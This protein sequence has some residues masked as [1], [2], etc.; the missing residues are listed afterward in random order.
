MGT[1]QSA[2]HL[3][4]EHQRASSERLPALLALSPL[5]SSSLDLQATF[6]AI[7][8]AAINLLGISAGM[9]AVDAALVDKQHPGGGGSLPALQAAGERARVYRVVAS[10]GLEHGPQIGEVFASGQ[11]LPGRVVRDGIPLLV[12][13]LAGDPRFQS[14]YIGGYIPASAIYAPLRDSSNVY[15]MLA[16]ASR[17]AQY[18]SEAD[19]LLLS[20]FAEQASHALLK[21]HLH[22]QTDE[23]AQLKERARLARD[24]H[25]MLE[26]PIDGM[27]QQIRDLSEHYQRLI[28]QDVGEAQ[29]P[30]ANL[31]D[32]LAEIGEALS[33]VLEETRQVSRN[34]HTLFPAPKSLTQLVDE[35]LS[36]I[37]RCSQIS[38][39]LIVEGTQPSLP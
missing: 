20:V 4:H 5:L 13:N 19:L 2:N 28:G 16:I 35:A 17:E 12:N 34:L 32:R 37:E 7:V 31:Y 36:S 9:L 23:M 3:A 38:T 14:W 15:G 33:T 8:Q 6:Q 26:L 29:M 25:A 18:F 10:V 27:L 11:S 1:D 39:R 24:L 21:A 30:G 22:S